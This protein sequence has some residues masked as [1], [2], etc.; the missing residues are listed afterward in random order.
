MLRLKV[1]LLDGGN[2]RKLNAVSEGNN[3]EIV[4]LIGIFYIYTLKL[5]L[6]AWITLTTL[7]LNITLQK[8]FKNIIITIFAYFLMQFRSLE[9]ISSCNKY[10]FGYKNGVCV[11]ALS[12]FYV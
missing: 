2:R 7:L 5:L 3:W 12:E 10:L 6:A 1:F 8:S 11:K 4:V 9:W